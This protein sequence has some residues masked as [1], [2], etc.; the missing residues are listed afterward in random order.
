MAIES[1]QLDPNAGGVSQ[2]EFD[3]HTHDYDKM[4]GCSKPSFCEPYSYTQTTTGTPNE[5]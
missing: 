4:T 3:A 1:F 2:E 5:T